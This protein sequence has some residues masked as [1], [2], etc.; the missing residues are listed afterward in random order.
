MIWRDQSMRRTAWVAAALLVMGVAGCGTAGPASPNAPAVSNSGST[1]NTTTKLSMQTVALTV[2]PGSRL[3]ADGKLHDT[4]TNPNF[5]VVKGVPVKLSVYNYSANQYTLVNTMLGLRL[6]IA[7]APR[8]GVPMISTITFTPTTEGAFSWRCT[9]SVDGHLDRWALNHQGF[10]EGIMHVVPYQNKQ[11]IYLAIKDGLHYAAA[12]GKLHD[13]YSPADFTVQKG[14]PVQVTVENF[15]TGSHSLTDPGLGINEVFT[16]ASGAGTP[17]ETTFTFTPNKTGTFP[18][19][20]IIACDT[21][22]GGWAMMHNG[23]MMGD[24]SVTS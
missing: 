21:G 14:I 7:A 8:Q 2:L 17:S 24:I 4:V 20:C 16:G 23:Y 18:W 10:M 1:T 3:G 6:H 19:S 15:D 5:T 13:S 9:A 11:Y 22:A 12:D